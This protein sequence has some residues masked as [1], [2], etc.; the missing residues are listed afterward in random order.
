MKSEHKAAIAALTAMCS[1]G[2]GQA[3]LHR[4]TPSAYSKHAGTERAVNW[5]MIGG[6]PGNSHYS[7][8]KQI[9]RSNV[10]KLQMAWKFDTGESGGLETTPIVVD[11]VLYTLTPIQEVIALDAADRKSVV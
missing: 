3:T 1:L 9:N 8:L 2:L 5:R 11:G 4:S 6:S 7:S 10:A